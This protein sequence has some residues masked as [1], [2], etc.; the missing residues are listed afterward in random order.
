MIYSDVISNNWHTILPKKSKYTKRDIDKVLIESLFDSKLNAGNT[1]SKK[2][3]RFIVVCTSIFYD[4]EY[5]KTVMH[6]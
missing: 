6:Y 1:F 2:Q 3:A 5:S 4:A